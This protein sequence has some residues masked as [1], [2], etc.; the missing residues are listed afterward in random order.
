MKRMSTARIVAR[1][2]LVMPS[3]ALAGAMPGQIPVRPASDGTLVPPAAVVP[4][5]DDAMAEPHPMPAS[6]SVMLTGVTSGLPVVG[7]AR[8]EPFNVA[9]AAESRSYASKWRA[10]GVAIAA[11]LEVVARCRTTPE[12]CPE[13]A[14]RF[15]AMVDRARDK[16]GRARLG[17]INRTVNLAIRFTSDALQHGAD[18]WT[19]PLATLSSGRGD[20]EDFVILKLMALQDL[21]MAASDLR[22]VVLRDAGRQQDHAVLA[23]RLDGRWVVLDN[24]RLVLLEDDAVHGYTALAAFGADGE[25][26]AATALAD[27]VTHEIEPPVRTQTPTAAPVNRS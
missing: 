25:P 9:A 27:K 8:R 7:A 14:S 5:R 6:W 13:P 19:P 15:L 1:I 21:G 18:R 20:C 4:S 24:R 22:L 10:A 3:L 11:D 26:D 2:L 23:V 12:Q 17:E 16:N